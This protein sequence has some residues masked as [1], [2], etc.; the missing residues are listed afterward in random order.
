MKA[1]AST[2]WGH[3][4]KTLV[5]TYKIIIHPFFTF[6]AP[7]WFPNASPSAIAS[8]QT[9]QNAVLRIATGCYKKTSI[10]HLHQENKVLSV[11]EHLYMLC[12]QFLANALIRDPPSHETVLQPQGTRKKNFTLY[13]KCI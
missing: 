13:S 11:K 4:M 5:N 1:L 6:G 10:A 8:L 3:D 12:E 2:N 9:I 7:I